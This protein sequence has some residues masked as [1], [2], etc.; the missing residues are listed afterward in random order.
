MALLEQTQFSCSGFLPTGPVWAPGN[1][2]GLKPAARHTKT[3]NALNAKLPLGL[4]SDNR[5]LV[6]Y[7]RVSLRNENLGYRDAFR[8]EYTATIRATGK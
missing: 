8:P 4:C 6:G 7:N 5:R 1:P 3:E 2:R